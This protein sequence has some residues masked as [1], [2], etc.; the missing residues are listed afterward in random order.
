MPG[1]SATIMKG[2]TIAPDAALTVLVVLA[3]SLVCP[4]SVPAAVIGVSSPNRLTR[5]EF[6]LERHEKTEEVPHYRAYYKNQ[7]IIRDSRLGTETGDGPPLGGPCVVESVQTTSHQ[8][9]YSMFP[10][11]RRQ[12]V[13][14]YTEAVIAIRE[15]TPPGPP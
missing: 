13:D 12:V 4:A 9:T 6:L 2:R 8:G 15:R 5:I 3:T 1:R 14:H 10:G 7:L 11:K